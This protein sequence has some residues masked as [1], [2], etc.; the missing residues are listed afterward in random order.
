MSRSL[1]S[2]SYFRCKARVV[3]VPAASAIELSLDDGRTVTVSEQQVETVIPS[4]KGGLVQIVRGELRG[5]VG[6]LIE[7]DSRRG[8]AVVQLEDDLQLHTLDFDD[9]CE[10]VR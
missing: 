1:S 9:I 5:Q 7:R 4:G 8:V 2:G 3:D 6:E 10:R